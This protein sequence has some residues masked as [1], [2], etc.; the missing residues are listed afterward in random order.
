MALRGMASMNST[1]EGHLLDGE[2]GL[3]ETDQRLG[4]IAI[5]ADDDGLELLF[6]GAAAG[7]ADDNRL[8]DIRMFWARTSSTS[9]GSILWPGHFDDQ[10]AATAYRC[11]RP[12]G[13]PRSP[14]EN[15][16][17]RHFIGRGLVE[18]AW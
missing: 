15:S 4:V 6:A 8:G 9:G 12:I 10:L 11:C 13:L 7:D 1:I 14:V 16:P 17:E 18:I 5:V 2:A 3:A